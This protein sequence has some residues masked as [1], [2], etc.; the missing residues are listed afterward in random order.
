MKWLKYLISAIIAVGVS[1]SLFE[2]SI[3]MMLIFFCGINIISISSRMEMPS[4]KKSK[5]YKICLGICI[6]G[7]LIIIVSKYA[8]NDF[9]IIVGAMLFSVT[10]SAIIIK[11]MIEYFARKS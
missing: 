6:I 5:A 1:V 10:F 8:Q 9:M 2:S 3:G 4:W 11:D 7:A